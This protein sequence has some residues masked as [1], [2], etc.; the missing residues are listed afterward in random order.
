MHGNMNVKFVQTDTYHCWSM[1]PFVHNQFL[2]SFTAIK[3]LYYQNIHGSDY[4]GLLLKLIFG[5]EIAI[6]MVYLCRSLWASSIVCR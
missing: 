2:F 1:I 6:R 5:I 4:L 3:F